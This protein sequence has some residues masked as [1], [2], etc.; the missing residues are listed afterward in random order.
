M[1][2]PLGP[3]NI[4]LFHRPNPNM[5]DA[6]FNDSEQQGTFV[7]DVILRSD[8]MES[9]IKGLKAAHVESARE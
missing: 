3:G 2:L 4:R 5:E 9:D 6:L 7:E 8:K 1:G